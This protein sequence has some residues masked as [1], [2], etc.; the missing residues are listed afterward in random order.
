MKKVYIGSTNP[1]KI[2]CTRLAFEKAFPG[3]KFDFKGVEVASEVSHQ[4]MNDEETLMGSINRANN[5]KETYAD[6]NYWVGIE[7]GIQFI[8]SELHAFAW[9]VIIS[10]NRIGKARTATFVLPPEIAMLVKSGI[11]LGSAD[12]IVFNR[13]NSKQKDGAVGIL[14]NGLIDRTR[15]YEHAMTLALIPFMKK[16]LFPA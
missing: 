2:A 10:V 4:P 13:V 12:D 8:G 9:V 11:E 7:G 16:D 15:Y 5:V 6:G 14:T 1:V 3:E